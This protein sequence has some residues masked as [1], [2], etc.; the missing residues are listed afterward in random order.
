MNRWPT[1]PDGSLRVGSSTQMGEAEASNMIATMQ[2]GM[3]ARARRVVVLEVL[4]EA[5]EAYG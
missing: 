1:V 3:A 2:Q 4:A 5:G